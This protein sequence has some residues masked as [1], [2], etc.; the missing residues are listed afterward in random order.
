MFSRA[1]VDARRGQTVIAGHMKTLSLFAVLSVSFGLRAGVAKEFRLPDGKPV[2]AITLP[3][4][5]KPE[6]IEKGVQGQT[7]D[8]SVYLCVETT[9]SEKEMATI[10][11]DTFAMLKQH[12]VELDRTVKRENKFLINGLPADELLYDG[13]DEDGPTTV[14]MTFVNVGKTAL[15]L[16]YWASVDGTKKHQP[17]VEKVLA[18]IK[19]IRK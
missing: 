19:A 14:S 5:W 12:K 6:V 9:T 17:E 7:A 13:K 2:A 18:S 4:T 11:D 8:N 3:E 10:I 15:V 1:D 16:T